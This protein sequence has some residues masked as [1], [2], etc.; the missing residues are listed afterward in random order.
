MNIFLLSLDFLSVPIEV[1]KN[2]PD[3]LKY[4]TLKAYKCLSTNY[5]PHFSKPME[6]DKVE[7]F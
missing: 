3:G 2:Q 1:C 4:H 6:A 7:S 5:C